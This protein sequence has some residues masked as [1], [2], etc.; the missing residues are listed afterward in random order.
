MESSL[1]ELQNIEN[2]DSM[3]QIIPENNIV[4]ENTSFIPQKSPPITLSPHSTTPSCHPMST[5]NITSLN[6]TTAI[7][8]LPIKEMAAAIDVQSQNK[9]VSITPTRTYLNENVTPVLLE[10][11]KIIAKER[12]SN[13]LQ[14]LGEYLISKSRKQ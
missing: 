10:G 6:D 13:P 3:E 11:M 4:C 9:M 5:S 12:P 7:H 1:N 14:V 8:A 2:R